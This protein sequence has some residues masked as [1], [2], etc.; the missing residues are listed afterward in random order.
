LKVGKIRS[1]AKQAFALSKTNPNNSMATEF[2][3]GKLGDRKSSYWNSNYHS[4]SGSGSSIIWAIYSKFL[5][6]STK[7]LDGKLSMGSISALEIIIRLKLSKV[8]EFMQK[9]FLNN[10]KTLQL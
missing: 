10:K 1:L 6:K 4:L 2:I 9:K 5:M 3:S 7:T 8:I